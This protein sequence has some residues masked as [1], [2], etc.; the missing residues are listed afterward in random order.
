MTRTEAVL[1]HAA[2]A[3]VLLSGLL[4]WDAYGTM[5]VFDDMISLCM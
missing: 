3:V 4:L 1:V 5:V 2:A